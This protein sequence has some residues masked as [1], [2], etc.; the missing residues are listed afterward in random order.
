MS[1]EVNCCNKSP[2]QNKSLV[3]YMIQVRIKPRKMPVFG[4]CS[5]FQ[6]GNVTMNKVKIHD[7][8]TDYMD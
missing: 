7:E 8:F 6:P 5:E 1:S 2:K 4:V 3:F